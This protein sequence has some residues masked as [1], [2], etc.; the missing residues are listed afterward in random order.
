MI[1]LLSDMPLLSSIFQQMVKAPGQKTIGFKARNVRTYTG[2][3]SVVTITVKF[4]RFRLVSIVIVLVSLTRMLQTDDFFTDNYGLQGRI[5]DEL[6]VLTSI[7]NLV[8]K[9]HP[10]LVGQ[11]PTTLGNLK[12][13]GQLGLYN[14][15]LTGGIPQELYDATNLNYIN[16]QNNQLE[17]GLVLRIEI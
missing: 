11:I 9:N 13:L 4:V 16:L 2:P 15:A 17:G 3:E 8:L 10:L 5:P 14:N 7:E 6:G 1:E 12:V